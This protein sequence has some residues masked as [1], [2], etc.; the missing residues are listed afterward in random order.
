MWPHLVGTN[1]ASAPRSTAPTRHEQRAALGRTAP[2]KHEGSHPDP[3]SV[4]SVG[5]A[6][7]RRAPRQWTRQTRRRPSTSRLVHCPTLPRRTPQRRA[8]RARGSRRSGA[9]LRAP[10]PLVAGAPHTRPTAVVE[11]PPRHNDGTSRI[12][13]AVVRPPGPPATP[14]MRPFPPSPSHAGPA[15]WGGSDRPAERPRPDDPAEP[16]ATRA[17]PMGACPEGTGRT[18][19]HPTQ[20][21]PE[22]RIELSSKLGSRGSLRP[23]APHLPR[24]RS[25][26]LGAPRAP[27]A[28]TSMPRC[29]TAR[30]APHR[31]T[32]LTA[33]PDDRQG[34]GCCRARMPRHRFAHAAR[35]VPAADQLPG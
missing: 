32:R 12:R 25:R 7:G 29:S 27:P 22:N 14:T 19:S 26:R 17:E 3:L 13:R 34:R 30:T 10:R 8:T 28:I 15:A 4:Q 2:R 6:H 31:S 11:S 1:Q 9:R 5:H 23:A 24:H 20:L 33:A 18:N 16:V 21:T 35:R